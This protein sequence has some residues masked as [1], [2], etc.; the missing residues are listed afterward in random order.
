ML[1]FAVPKTK[2]DVAEFPVRRRAKRRRAQ[3]LS[4][5][6]YGRKEM[7]ICN[8]VCADGKLQAHRA[9]RIVSGPRHTHTHTHTLFNCARV[10]ELWYMIPKSRG[11]NWRYAVKLVH[12][13]YWTKSERRQCNQMRTCVNIGDWS[14]ISSFRLGSAVN[15]REKL[16]KIAAIWWRNKYVLSRSLLIA[17][18]REC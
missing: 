16:R 12:D 6:V 8:E 18:G 11:V 15:P 17:L 4:D 5:C 3:F 7:M 14:N 2:T 1:P 9:H 10:M 13:C